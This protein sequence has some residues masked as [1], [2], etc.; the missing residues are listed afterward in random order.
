MQRLQSHHHPH[1]RACLRYQKIPQSVSINK[2]HCN[3][4]FMSWSN[5]TLCWSTL[6]ISAESRG[7]AEKVQGKYGPKSGI[8]DLFSAFRS[9]ARWSQEAV[10]GWGTLCVLILAW[11]YKEEKKQEGQRGGET[12]GGGGVRELV[13]N[14]KTSDILKTF[15]IISK[16]KTRDISMPQYLHSCTC[17]SKAVSAGLP[18]SKATNRKSFPAKLAVPSPKAND[19]HPG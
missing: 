1:I 18:I 12:G 2:L 19:R 7:R 14:R 4:P 15:R 3:M 13:K 8:S 5:D 16:V 11:A 10:G 17:T 9:G 6:I